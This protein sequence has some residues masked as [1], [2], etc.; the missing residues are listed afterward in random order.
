MNVK[1]LMNSKEGG[2]KRN[3][4]SVVLSEEMATIICK[5]PIS[6]LSNKDNVRALNDLKAP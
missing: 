1:D 5:I 6:K 2:W 3:V 4:I